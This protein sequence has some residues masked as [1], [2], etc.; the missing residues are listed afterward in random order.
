MVGMFEIITPRPRDPSAKLNPGSALPT[1]P[2]H[3][4]LPARGRQL[5]IPP[6][7]TVYK[8]AKQ[9]PDGAF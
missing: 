4:P 3:E 1:N 8:P 5:K 9:T 7:S 2:K 6:A